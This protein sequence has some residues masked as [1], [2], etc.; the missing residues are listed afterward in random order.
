MRCPAAGS[1][2]S[3]GA[4]KASTRST[5]CVEGLG[6]RSGRV[7]KRP[8]RLGHRN[9][10]PALTSSNSRAVSCERRRSASR[11]ESSSRSVVVEPQRV[12]DLGARGQAQCRRADAQLVLA[13][14]TSVATRSPVERAVER[15]GHPVA[16]FGRSTRPGLPSASPSLRPGGSSCAAA[17]GATREQP[18]RGAL[19]TTRRER[20]PMGSLGWARAGRRGCGPARASPVCG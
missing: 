13:R 1:P 19:Q 5:P 18:R 17:P 11:P 14:R 20:S 6:V 8:A 15:R 10:L 4:W 12:I 3:S 9:G 16:G 7:R 2:P